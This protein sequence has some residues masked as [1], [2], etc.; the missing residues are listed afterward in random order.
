MRRVVFLLGALA[1]TALAACGAEEP[2]PRAS[3]PSSA[4]VAAELR[5]SPAPLAALHAQANELLPGGAPA[6]RARL[7]EL[8][9]HPVVVNKWASWCGPCRA[10]FPHFQS[11]ARTRG[12]EV[13]FLGVDSNDAP[14][15]AKG[16]LKKF[17]VPYPSYDDPNGDIGQGV[18][19]TV[20]FPTTV[21]YDRRGK[22]AFLK[23]GGY[24]T[25][26]ELAADIERYAK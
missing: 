20:V 18:L 14:G 13:A 11:L 6:F 17:P 21:F 10:E 23:Q 7:R 1:L 26:R 3:A 5:G 24:A 2:S 25:E 9:G 16:F 22:L 8:R 12:K 15:P 4:R 19:K